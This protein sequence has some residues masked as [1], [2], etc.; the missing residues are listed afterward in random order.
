M[1]FTRLFVLVFSA[2][3]ATALTKDFPPGWNHLAQKP[4]L[5]WR[6]WNA[7]H[8]AITQDIIQQNIDAITA[9]NWTID[10]KDHVSLADFGY[11]SVGIDEGWEGCGQGVNGTQHAANGDPV[12]NSK[13]PNM[14]ALVEY[15]HAKGV[16]M[17]WYLNGCACGERKAIQINCSRLVTTIMVQESLER[18][19]VMSA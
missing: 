10:G 16:K 9:K 11:D 12:I 18:E 3:G 8:A 14:S 15:G 4:P 6:S 2:I 13:F 5:G 17:G 7:Y 19:I 1:S